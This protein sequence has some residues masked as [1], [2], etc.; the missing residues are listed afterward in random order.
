MNA[1][2]YSPWY[3]PASYAPACLCVCLTK[4]GAAMGAAGD[5]AGGGACC[6]PPGAYIKSI[7][8]LIF[9]MKHQHPALRAC[10]PRRQTA[11]LRSASMMATREGGTRGGLASIAPLTSWPPHS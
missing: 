5:L 7:L 8:G 6:S 2:K 4:A 3:S 9:K 1:A 11:A 10:T